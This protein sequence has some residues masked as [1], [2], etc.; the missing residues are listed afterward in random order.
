[1]KITYLVAASRDGFIARDNGDV[2]WL[3]ELNI[4][5]S[6]TNLESFFRSVDG[7]VMGRKTYDFVFNYGTWPYENKPTWVVTRTNIEPLPGADLKVVRDINSVLVEAMQSSVEHLWLVGGGQ[8]ASSFLDKMWLTNISLSEMPITLG[9]GIPMFSRH[10]L[11]NIA[12]KS[13]SVSEKRGFKQ[14]EV[15]LE[16]VL[17]S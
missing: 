4:D 11:E 16:S 15:E 7:L 12:F 10:K 8:L 3:E 14:I 6:E 5:S 13:R 17:G 9:T 1:M 2:S